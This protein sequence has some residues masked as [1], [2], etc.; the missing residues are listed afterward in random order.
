MKIFLVL[1]LFLSSFVRAEDYTTYTKIGVSYILDQPTELKNPKGGSYT[2]LYNDANLAYHI[3]KGIA[4]QDY[5]IGIYWTD[6]LNQTDTEKHRP[7]K[8]EIFIDRIWKTEIVDIVIG[9]GFK[10]KDDSTIKFEDENGSYTYD[11]NSTH[12]INRFT[13]RI[14]LSDDYKNFVFGLC[15]HSQWLQGKP[16]ND[17]WEYHKTEFSVAYQF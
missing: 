8:F 2:D 5:R 9:T 11:T 15:H 1:L 13:S 6:L 16:I 17:E 4:V 3:E 7:Y 12:I 10:I 14:C